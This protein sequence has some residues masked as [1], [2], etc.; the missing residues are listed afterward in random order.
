MQS[1]NVV[2]LEEPWSYGWEELPPVLSY[3][4]WVDRRGGAWRVGMG[5]E[6]ED[7]ALTA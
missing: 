2:S 4:I 6:R 3:F 7:G 1:G 5:R